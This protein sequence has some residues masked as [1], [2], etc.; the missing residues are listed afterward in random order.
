MMKIF[1]LVLTV[2]SVACFAAKTKV[3]TSQSATIEIVGKGEKY[4]QVAV[5][6]G[7]KWCR[8]QY[9]DGGVVRD[10]SKLCTALHDALEA[11]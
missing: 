6:P 11:K 3:Q 5:P 10:S 4:V 9:P 1:S 8:I 2:F 7:Q